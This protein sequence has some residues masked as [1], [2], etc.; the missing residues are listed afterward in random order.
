MRRVRSSAVCLP[1]LPCDEQTVD[2]GP[3]KALA[4]THLKLKLRNHE[5][6]RWTCGLNWLDRA[7]RTIRWGFQSSS[8][9]LLSLPIGA[10]GHVYCT[11]NRLHI[12]QSFLPH[13]AWDLGSA[14]SA[15]AVSVTSAGVTP[16]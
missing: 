1:A 14:L 5:N 9:E 16:V 13:G 12:A 2:F 4:S 6:W 11:C 10:S 8:V 3:P 7:K 15:V